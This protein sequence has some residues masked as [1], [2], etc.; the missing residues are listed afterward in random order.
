MLEELDK[1]SIVCKPSKASLFVREVEFASP[2]VVP[3][4]G[5]LAALHHS[6]RPQTISKLR[7]LMGFCK[8][9]SGYV[10]IYAKLL[11]PLHK[12][13]QVGKF[14]GRNGSKK[15]LAW[16]PDA[17]DAFDRLKQRL[18]GQFGLFLVDPDKG[19]VLCTD[20]LNYAVGAVVEG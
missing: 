7:S 10:R 11:G 8:Y 16:T 1:H 2:V 12:M 5:V 9:Y 3:M 19:F 20:A 14:D 15:K 17:E 6:E 13:L 18:L 4:P